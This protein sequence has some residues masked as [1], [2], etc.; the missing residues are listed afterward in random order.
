M[1]AASS[2]WSVKNLE[3]EMK[4]PKPAINVTR[5][6]KPGLPDGIFSNQKSQFFKVLEGLEME[7]F[8]TNYGHLVHFSV[9]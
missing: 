9:I 6:V 1:T 4:R 3:Q 5:T 8:G 7:D 2:P